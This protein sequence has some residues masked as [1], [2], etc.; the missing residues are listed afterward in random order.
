[1]YMQIIQ[2][3]DIFLRQ[4]TQDIELPISPEN[5]ELIE[6][7]IKDFTIAYQK[8]DPQQA[9]R[10]IKAWNTEH[11]TFPF[12]DANGKPNY[13]LDYYKIWL[14]AQSEK[15]IINRIIP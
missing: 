11:P 4:P 12:I 9:I 10:E 2:Q 6:N 7:M 1:M 3:P 13:S 14:K 5:E 8:G 15:N